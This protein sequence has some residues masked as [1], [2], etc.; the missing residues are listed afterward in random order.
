MAAFCCT[1]KKPAGSRFGSTDRFKI[2]LWYNCHTCC[3]YLNISWTTNFLNL[4]DWYT[5]LLCTSPIR[6]FHFHVLH[7]SITSNP[8][9]VHH[10]LKTKFHNYPKGMLFS[11]HRQEI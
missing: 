7:N 5:H 10:I 8:D 2:K 3:T 4:C 6:S 1:A 11:T 9:N